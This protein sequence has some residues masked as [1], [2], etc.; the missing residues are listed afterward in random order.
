MADTELVVGIDLGTTNSEIAAFVDGQV[1]VLGPAPGMLP[2]CV[3]ITPAGDLLVGQEARRQQLL[4][5]ERTVRSIKRKGIAAVCVDMWEPFR[6]S[7]EEWVPDCKIIYDKFHVL[8][9]A[10]DAVDEVRKAEFFRQGREKRELIKGKK[11]LLLSR[12]RNLNGEHRGDLNE[13]FQINRRVFKAY[14]LKESLEGLWDYRY[15][16]A[17]LN[18][19]E[20]WEDQL[21]WQRLAP[22][23]KLADMLL[24]HVEGIVNY[25]R[26]KVRF[27]VVEANLRPAVVHNEIG[28]AH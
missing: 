27:G 24:K 3:G 28:R 17:M 4:Y 14:L 25:C 2:S 18:Y 23:E 10:N 16:G 13:L 9:H 26:T 7:I 19:L 12:W 6:L 20:K 11:W 15:P 22:F 5:P 8:G 1:R 21:K